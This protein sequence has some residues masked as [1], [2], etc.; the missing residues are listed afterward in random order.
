MKIKISEK[1]LVRSHSRPKLARRPT[2]PV[3]R[4]PTPVPTRLAIPP[5]LLSCTP[6]DVEWYCK[7]DICMLL[8]I[9]LKVC[10]DCGIKKTIGIPHMQGGFTDVI[11]CDRIHRYFIYRCLKVLCYCG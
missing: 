3:P 10:L 8:L 2:R 1:I 6:R 5:P 9:D 11:N 4:L 7:G